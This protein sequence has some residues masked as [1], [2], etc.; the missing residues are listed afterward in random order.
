MDVSTTPS[1][2]VSS[3]LM[4]NSKPESATIIGLREVTATIE[5]SAIRCLANAR[6][7][8]RKVRSLTDPRLANNVLPKENTPGA[9][10][11]R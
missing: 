3:M 8:K 10:N 2:R 9:G 6:T 5:R 1:M 11:I 4:K 7:R